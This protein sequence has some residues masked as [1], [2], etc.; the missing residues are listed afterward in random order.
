MA[1]EQMTYIV[2]GD[3]LGAIQWGLSD[4]IGFGIAWLFISILVFTVV[5]MKTN[6]YGISG[7]VFII[8]TGMVAPFLPPEVQLYFI[9]IIVGMLAS[10]I[11]KIYRG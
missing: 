7:L 11:Y 8:F 5:Y 9:L 6:S 1:S 3:W 10:M 4:Y 2:Q